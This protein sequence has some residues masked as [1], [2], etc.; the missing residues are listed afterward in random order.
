MSKFEDK[1]VRSDMNSTWFFFPYFKFGSSITMSSKMSYEEVQGPVHM[2]SQVP[3]WRQSN[4]FENKAPGCW[5]S[6][7]SY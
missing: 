7:T 4:R 5:N 2:G 1:R 6:K 3:T